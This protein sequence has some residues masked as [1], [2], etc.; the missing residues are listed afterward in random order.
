MIIE[1][2]FYVDT[3]S[4]NEGA[5]AGEAKMNCLSYAKKVI[6]GMYG[7]V[8]MMRAT[9]FAC[10]LKVTAVRKE[11]FHYEY[12]RDMHADLI[13]IEEVLETIES[14]IFD[15]NDFEAFDN[16][17]KFMSDV[18]TIVEEKIFTIDKVLIYL[19]IS[20]YIESIEQCDTEEF[21]TEWVSI[22]N[23]YGLEWI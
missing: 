8:G 20:A 13:H 23:I 6:N 19:L 14:Q 11:L 12:Y 22:K 15:A 5:A 17:E 3:D 21:K 2:K 7:Y 1:G 4:F 16:K 10:R 18:M 9:S